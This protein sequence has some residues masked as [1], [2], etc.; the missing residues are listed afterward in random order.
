MFYRQSS[1]QEFL[2]SFLYGPFLQI[3]LNCLKATEPLRADSLLFTTMFPWTGDVVSTS[4]RCRTMLY[5]VV[6]MLKRCRVSTRKSP[7]APGTHLIDPEKMKALESTNG[8]EHGI[9]L[10]YWIGHPAPLPT[11]LCSCAI[12][13]IFFIILQ[14]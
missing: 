6:S 3:G 11:P 5:D 13:K 4:I 10:E 14:N 8:F 2:S 9:G 1:R 12:M 7:G